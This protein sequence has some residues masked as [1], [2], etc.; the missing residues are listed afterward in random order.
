MATRRDP[1]L[2]SGCIGCGLLRGQ[3]STSGA[4]PTESTTPRRMA[5]NRRSGGRPGVGGR[6]SCRVPGLSRMHRALRPAAASSTDPRE[7]S[8]P[9]EGVAR[10]RRVTPH[11]SGRGLAS[12]PLATSATHGSGLPPGRSEPGSSTHRLLV[13]IS[14]SQTVHR[15]RRF[16][17]SEYDRPQGSH[18]SEQPGSHPAENRHADGIGRRSAV[19]LFDVLKTLDSAVAGEMDPCAVL[20]ADKP[21]ELDGLG[22]DRA[23]GLDVAAHDA[24]LIKGFRGGLNLASASR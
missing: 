17:E 4:A 21:A 5:G 11:D 12:R 16:G 2:V 15:S 7:G 19:P 24:P 8:A 13:A 6:S 3:L 10:D 20:I 9:P 18:A 23:A 14:A 1:L 22:T